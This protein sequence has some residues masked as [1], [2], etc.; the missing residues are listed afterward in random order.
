VPAEPAASAPR[1]AQQAK[2][3]VVPLARRPMRPDP[4]MPSARLPT[5]TAAEEILRIAAAR[6]ASTVYVVAGAGPMVRADGEISSI[7]VEPLT[8]SDVERMIIE[9][10]GPTSRDAGGEWK[11]D[12]AQV[13]RVRCLTF[14][15]HRGPGLILQMISPQALSADQLGLTS[16]VQALCGQSDGLVVVTGPRGSG[17]STLMSAFVD[18][19]NRTRSDHVITLESQIEFVHQSRRSFVS[20]REIRGD[21]AAIVAAIRSA[22][23]EDPDVLLIEDLRS[24]DVTTAALEA[25]ESGRLVLGSLTAA[26]TQAAVDKLIELYPGERKVLTQTSLAT[27]L[28]GVVSQVLVRRQR[29]GRMA[30]REVLLNTPPVAAF[31][32]DGKTGQLPLAIES[33]RRHG[34]MPLNDSLAALVRDGTVHVTEAWRKALDK[35]SLLA[36]LKRVGIDTSFAE[37]LA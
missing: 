23:R 26:S 20:Q 14:H 36:A 15:D 2:P 7:E 28:R 30:A 21:A 17:K 11:A 25:A 18:L 3:I 10:G 12:V 1:P 37:R 13:G 31:I 27:A 4:S 5:L 8:A 34:M 29:G 19:I 6:G 33:G 16:E 22:L 32:Q 35:E 24:A 9:L